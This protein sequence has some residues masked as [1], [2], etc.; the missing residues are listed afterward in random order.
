M[1]A[2]EECD[3][4]GACTSVGEVQRCTA[5]DQC[6]AG[7]TCGVAGF[8]NC[9]GTNTGCPAGQECSADFFCFMPCTGAGQCPSGECRPVGGDGCAANCTMETTRPGEF[10]P[11]T[12]GIPCTTQGPDCAG[13]CVQSIA[14]PVPVVLNG[15]TELITGDMRTETVMGPE[16][17]VITNPG[18]VPVSI[19][20]SGTRFTPTS[21]FNTICACV[22]SVPQ[23]LFGPGN[24]GAGIVG[25][26]DQ[27]LVDT[28]F[29][30]EQDHNTTP[31]APGNS[32]SAAGFPDD[33]E[34]DDEIFTQSVP[35]FACTE[36]QDPLCME[37]RYLHPGICNSPRRVTFSGGRK[38]K[39]SILLFNSTAITQLSDGGACRTEP[40]PGPCPF[41]DYGADCIPCT[42]D[43]TP[44]VVV[45][46][47]P[48]TSGK[49][50]VRIIDANNMGGAQPIEPGA[51][52][53]ATPCKVEETG[54]LVDC[55]MLEGNNSLGGV[56][57]TAFPG[58]DA[59]TLRDTV[60]TTTL[61][62]GPPTP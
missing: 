7:Q 8:C 4:R 41:P 62:A 10:I 61:A 59:M 46:V 12:S 39:G 42:R 17:Q 48:T 2:G 13:S 16:G 14:L 45:N 19:K 52:C 37:D 15:T 60:T 47:T 24:A 34:C 58:I 40:L 38:P 57:A 56:L 3:D 33:P 6:P 31:G 5:N 27:G 28:D 51:T 35:S 18:E 32:G 25:C 55:A 1:Q 44:E 50:S 30:V 49:A 20:A 36:R 53:G 54:E 22:K 23:P 43:D 11:C 26:G 21:V 9:S 29:L